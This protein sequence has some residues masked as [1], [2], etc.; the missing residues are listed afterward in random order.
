MFLTGLG[1]TLTQSQHNSF[2]L[3]RPSWI[4]FVVFLV[5]LSEK[6]GDR[7]TIILKRPCLSY[8]LCKVCVTCIFEFPG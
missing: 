8:H 2:I 6:D 4:I 5:S 7:S 1:H 3:S